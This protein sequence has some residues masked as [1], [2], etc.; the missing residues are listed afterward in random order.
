MTVSPG[1]E[2]QSVAPCPLADPAF[3]EIT[4][5]NEIQPNQNDPAR[6]RGAL[7]SDSHVAKRV[8]R[9]RDSHASF[10]IQTHVPEGVAKLIVIFLKLF[11][12]VK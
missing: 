1:R 4:I 11:H 3:Q 5:G 9:V 2:K 12:P 7:A 10:L 6:N 8:L